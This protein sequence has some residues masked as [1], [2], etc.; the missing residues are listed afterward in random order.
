[1]H[2]VSINKTGL[3][4][5][6]WDDQSEKWIQRSISD[7]NLPINWF[8][9]HAVEIEE[10]LSVRGIL[11]LLKPHSKELQEYFI[12][13]LAGVA[14]DELIMIADSSKIYQEKIAPTEVFLLKIA[15]VSKIMENEKPINFLEIHPVLMGIEVVKEDDPD[16]DV[17]HPLTS[18]SFEDWCNLPLVADD[19]L[20]LIDSETS[21][22]YF[23]GV[24][25][26]TLHEVIATILSQ[27]AITVKASQA[28]STSSTTSPI[29]EGPVEISHVWDWLDDLD[30]FF[31]S[32]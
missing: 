32:K 1:M 7:S 6:F 10:G 13:N 18:I 17:L 19:W 21:A 9:N 29:K 16:Q 5:S 11:D 4:F 30:N 15:E 27:S 25:N 26:W 28:V 31:L 20:E 3:L 24:V 23:E 8:M 2:K 12:Q 22:V 14:L